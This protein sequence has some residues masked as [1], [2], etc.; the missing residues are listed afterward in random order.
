MKKNNA[1]LFICQHPGGVSFFKNLSQILKKCD[2][3]I[4]IIL[5]KINHPYFSK[6]NFK[7]YEKYFD[8]II[9][10]DFV[11]YK[12]NF[13]VGYW[14]IFKFIKKLKKT[15]VNL[16]RDFETID[17]FLENSAWL[18]VN[19]LLYNLSKEKNVKNIVRFAYGEIKNQQIKRDGFKTFLLR[20][21]SLPF[22][23][24]KVIATSTKAGKFVNFVYQ[25]KLP[26]E[27]IKIINPAK[28]ETGDFSTLPYPIFSNFYPEQKKDI[29]IIFGC[30]SIPDVYSEYIKDKNIFEEK[31]RKFFKAME[32][33]YPDCKLYYKPHPADEG[34]VPFWVKKEKYKIFNDNHSAETIFDLY[35]QRIRAVYSFS[36]TS[37][38]AA[39]FF[40]IPS[41]TYYR[42]IYNKAGIET[43]DSFFELDNIKSKFLYNLSNLEEIGRID[44]LER[45]KQLDLNNISQRYKQLLKII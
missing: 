40:G 21:Y 39:S 14:G 30:I 31:S 32:S 45:P 6:F 38:I 3:N 9:E 12:R 43:L 44:N 2:K 24:Y 25:D 5:F 41:Y 4:K 10:F 15:M 19:I 17:L 20:F 42:Y 37:V 16:S 23:K 33:K 29:I 36:S 28:E 22:K 26:G 18:P 35:N 8:E 7:P 11:T 27:I 13:L 34:N 1:K